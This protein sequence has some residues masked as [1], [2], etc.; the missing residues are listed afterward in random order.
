MYFLSAVFPVFTLWLW[1]FW[2]DRFLAFDQGCPAVGWTLFLF[3]GSCWVTFALYTTI[4]LTRHLRRTPQHE[5]IHIS[6]EIVTFQPGPGHPRI[7]LPRLNGIYHLNRTRI[8]MEIPGLDEKLKGLRLGHLSDFHFGK[9]C[10]GDFIRHA[11]DC[12]MELEPEVL[13]VTGDFLNFSKYLDECFD[14]LSKLNAPLGIYTTCGNH[15]YWAGIEKIHAGIART[16]FILLE[17]RTVEVQRNGARFLLSG[18]ESRW[19]Q[20]RIPLDYIPNDSGT[21]RIVLSHTPDEFP[22]LVSRNPHLVLS[23]HTHG[24]QVC[25]PFFGPVVVPS[26][27][28]RRYASGLFKH[29]NS[30]LYVSRGI[31]CYPPFRMLCDPEVTLIEFV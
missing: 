17:D 13:A 16:G 23:G 2:G 18:I 28:G 19:N 1:W 4:D 9:H 8:T 12:L 11:V 25:F 22:R 20:S 14:L 21:L 15:D 31:G 5:G 3:L 30:F 7:W 24:G 29:G 6:K 10:H 27:F 26:D